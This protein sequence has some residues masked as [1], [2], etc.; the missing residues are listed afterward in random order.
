[1]VGVS[2]IASVMRGLCVV[3]PDRPRAVRT[4]K[5]PSMFAA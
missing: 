2:V 3:V 4:S 5:R 1:M